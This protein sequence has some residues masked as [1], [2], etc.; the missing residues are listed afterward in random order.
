MRKQYLLGSAASIVA[1]AGAAQFLGVSSAAAQ[2]QAAASQAEAT[3]ASSQIGEIVVTANKRE[4]NLQDVA[5]SVQAISQAAVERQ[6]VKEFTDL[7]RVNPELRINTGIFTNITIRGIRTSN[8]GPTVDQPNAVH[9]DGVYVSRSTALN[10]L[11][12][13][14]E[15]VEV[16]AGPQG[17]LYGR[18][19]A[20]GTI[21]IITVK[22]KFDNF[23]GRASID[24]GNYNSVTL[25]GAINVPISDNFAFRVA[26]W[27][28]K[29][30][31]Y[32]DNGTDNANQEAG[33]LS[34]LWQPSPRDTLFATID[35]SFN[36]PRNVGAQKI[37]NV[38][39]NP[40][41]ATGTCTGTPAPFVCLVPAGTPGSVVV[42]IPTGGSDGRSI[43]A[44]AGS[45]DLQKVHTVSG[46]AMIQ[47]D[48][49]FEWANLTAQ[50]AYRDSFSNNTNGTATGFNVDPRLI[51]TTVLTPQ[52]WGGNI[53][54]TRWNTQEIRLTSPG[55]QTLTWVGGLY[56]FDEHTFDPKSGN[57]S[58]ARTFPNTPTTLGQ[59][60]YT[61]PLRIGNDASNTLNDTIAYAAFGQATYTFADRLHLTG[62]IRYND[63]KKHGI[64][65]SLQNGV[66]N[67][68]TVFDLKRHWTAWTYKLNASY[69]LTPANMV[70]ADYSTGFKSGGFAFGST[71]AY[72]PETI[73]AYEVGT[74]NRFFNGRLTLN[75]SAWWYDYTNIVQ[76]V[77]EF[78]FDTTLGRPNGFLNTTNGKKAKLSG[79]SI[80]AD[81]LLTDND[82]VSVNA[83]HIKS[84]FKEYSTLPLQQ[85]GLSN[86]FFPGATPATFD[87]AGSPFPSVP[88]WAANFSY[89]HIFHVFRGE[90]DL[91]VAAHYTGARLATNNSVSLNDPNAYNWIYTG[92]QTTFDASA[93]FSSGDGR[94]SITGYIRNIGN[95]DV[96]YNRAYVTNSTQYLPVS[97][98]RVFYAYQ[99]E[100]YYAPRTFGVI[101]SANF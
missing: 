56:R 49:D 75:G 86:G 100:N 27:R 66:I 64:G 41:I 89:D 6:G 8:F 45:Q 26:Y 63:E 98:P 38:L 10:G 13:D 88:D 25:N 12:F 79:Q 28:N 23:G 4:E 36:T 2:A 3:G 19:S 17:T 81:W 70:Y 76:T 35:K 95:E 32:N 50:A 87:Y 33:R 44:F 14:T 57:Y 91:Q 53:L 73:K 43:A 60:L 77:F 16:L 84:R 48:H 15:R 72:E 74:K 52:N 80:T 37:R 96:I 21:N 7:M 29:H 93:R 34:L 18:N 11:F 83:T 46:G 62:G 94:W 1:L 40:S 42:P 31:G 71:P 47:Y 85:F 5:A 67:P 39:K 97:D 82:I 90:L 20:G 55:N 92:G 65:F 9:L 99:T 54:K 68:R 51:T 58:Y 24:Y 59:V 61:Q 101:L 78:Y 22:P 69:D 30:D